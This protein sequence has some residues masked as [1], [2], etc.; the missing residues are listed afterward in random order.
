M[1]LNVYE[2]MEPGNVHSRGLKELDDA[3]AKQLSIIF[4]KS[5]LLG[6]VPGDWKK[7][8]ELQNG[9]GGKGPKRSFSSKRSAMGRIANHL[10]KLPR[11]PAYL[12]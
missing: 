8:I 10:I 9:L 5:W 11:I 4:G 3:V 12:D 6:E 7:T 1:G 2:F